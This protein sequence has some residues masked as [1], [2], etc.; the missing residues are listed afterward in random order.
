LGDY[1]HIF[2]ARFIKR[3]TRNNENVT[4]NLRSTLKN[5]SR[6]WSINHYSDDEILQY[7]DWAGE[8]FKQK[9][10]SYVCECQRLLQFLRNLPN[11]NRDRKLPIPMPGMPDK[12]R[13]PMLSDNEVEAIC[14]ATVVDKIKPNMVIRLAVA[15]IYGGRVGELAQLSS[16]DF[17]LDGAKSYIWIPTMKRGVRKK[18]PIPAALLPLFQAPIK[19]T[20]VP[21]LHNKLKRVLSKAEIPWQYGMGFHSFRRNVVTALDKLGTQSDIAVYKF[22]RWSTPRHLGMLDRYRRTP[23]EESDMKILENH[24][25]VKL[26]QDIIP[27]L[28]KI[29]PHYHRQI[30]ILT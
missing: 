12:F 7:L 29:N 18:Q 10:S 16:N 22:M 13:Q 30:D 9:Q 20:S 6:F 3:F 25:R 1:G 17:Y 27:Y 24:P 4:G 23:S 19:A 11:A 21:T 15:S 26:W 5:P 14:W 8:H 28:V 2:P